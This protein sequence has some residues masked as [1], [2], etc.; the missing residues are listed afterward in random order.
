M[1]ATLSSSRAIEA[2]HPVPSVVDRT[3]DR[4]DGAIRVRPTLFDTSHVVPSGHSGSEQGEAQRIS[5]AAGA[6]AA[7]EEDMGCGATH[8]PSMPLGELEN[9]QPAV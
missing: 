2:S 1:Q 9:R 5:G 6:H 7:V 3:L 8:G 4:T